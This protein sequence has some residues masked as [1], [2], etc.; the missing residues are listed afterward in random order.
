VSGFVELGNVKVVEL[1][2]G[3]KVRLYSKMINWPE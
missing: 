2:F 3:G 1:G